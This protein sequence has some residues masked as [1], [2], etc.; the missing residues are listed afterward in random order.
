MLLILLGSSLA[1]FPCKKSNSRG[2]VKGGGGGDS[3]R[4]NPAE[5]SDIFNRNE[6]AKKIKL[7]KVCAFAISF[8]NITYW[9]IKGTEVYWFDANSWLIITPPFDI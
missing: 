8:Q 2:W 6:N 5:G 9:H 1:E 4:N 3:V 7:K